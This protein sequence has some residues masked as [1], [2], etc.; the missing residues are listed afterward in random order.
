M[1]SDP[2]KDKTEE[3]IKT[4]LNTTSL[5]ARHKVREQLMELQNNDQ[6]VQR[7]IDHFAN[8]L[9]ANNGPTQLK[10][11]VKRLTQSPH[12]NQ[13]IHEWR[14]TTTPA[15]SLKF[16]FDIDPTLSEKD[17]AKLQ[18]D[19]QKMIKSGKMNGNQFKMN[20]PDDLEQQQQEAMYKIMLGATCNENGATILATRF[21]ELMISLGDTGGDLDVTLAQ[22]NAESLK[23]TLTGRVNNTFGSMSIPSPGFVDS[24]Q[25]AKE[26]LLKY[27]D[28]NTSHIETGPEGPKAKTPFD[29]DFKPKDPT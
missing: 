2:T 18:E 10:D 20:M 14:Q 5:E 16:V 25:A 27:D 22:R 19:A 15:Q 24:L 12:E 29:M 7:H 26:E 9:P 17:L 8:A 6:D 23:D 21:G 1:A 11:C 4:Y 3:L 28:P 13:S